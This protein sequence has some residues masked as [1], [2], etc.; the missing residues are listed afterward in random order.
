M[1]YLL[2][3]CLMPMKPT[4]KVTPNVT[5][6]TKKIEANAECC[7]SKM[8]CCGMNA[9]K[10][11]TT[12]LLAINTILL[13]LILLNQ[14]KIESMKVGGSENY[15]LLKQLFGNETYQKQQRTQ[16]E[17]A[18]QMFANGGQQAQGP[19]GEQAAPQAPAMQKAPAAQ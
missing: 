16:I 18:L 19:Q 13:L 7:S 2:L 4:K 3:F 11:L 1:F 8:P 12:V 15:G 14:T 6:E 9:R 17:Q 10:V 5:V